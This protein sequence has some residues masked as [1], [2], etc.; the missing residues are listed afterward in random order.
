MVGGQ[1]HSEPEQG[2]NQSRVTTALIEIRFQFLM[3]L[4]SHCWEM[5]PNWQQPVFPMIMAQH[6]AAVAVIF[7]IYITMVFGIKKDF[8]K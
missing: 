6:P 4:C 8:T 3:L 7:F 2:G 1:V 5:T